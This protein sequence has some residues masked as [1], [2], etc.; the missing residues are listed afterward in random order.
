[1]QA[2]GAYYDPGTRHMAAM[3]GWRA[4]PMMAAAP[5][6]GARPGWQ[7]FRPQMLPSSPARGVSTSR[8]TYA[9]GSRQ[10]GRAGLTSSSWWTDECVPFP[11]CSMLSGLGCHRE[12]HMLKP[13]YYGWQALPRRSRLPTPPRPAALPLPG[14]RRRPSLPPH[15]DSSRPLHSCQVRRL[16]RR[17]LLF[18]C[19][20]P[21]ISMPA[22]LP[23]LLLIGRSD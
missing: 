12:E 10:V 7:M 2:S 15:S 14:S 18:N 9:H 6:P 21:F 19:L 17:V 5:P 16:P 22:S 20:P 13:A 1:M 3:R 11:R 4:A 23:N 8:L